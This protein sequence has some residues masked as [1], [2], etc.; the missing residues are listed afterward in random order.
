MNSLRPYMI[1]IGDLQ[2]QVHTRQNKVNRRNALHY[3]AP[4]GGGWGVVRVACLVPE[5]LVL[6]VIPIGCG[7]HGGVAALQ[8]GDSRMVRYLLVEE[9]EIVVGSYLD[10]VEKAVD[11]LIEAEKPAGMILFSTCMDDL[12]GADFDGIIRVASERHRIPVVRAKMNPIMSDTKKPPEVMIQHSIYQFLKYPAANET[13]EDVTGERHINVIGSFGQLDSESEIHE[14]LRH[15]GGYRLRHI[16]ECATLEAFESMGKSRLN[17]LVKPAGA[18]AV[19]AM[20]KRGKQ[21]FVEGF[22]AFRPAEINENYQQLSQ[23]LALPGPLDTTAAEAAAWHLME[24]AKPVLKG[25]T[26]AI[27]AT[28]NAR[29]FE[30]ARF[31]TELGIHVRY[32]LAKAVHDSEEKHVAWLKEHAPALQVIPDLDPSLS[33]QHTYVDQ[34][35]LCLGL[36]AAVYF[37]P[38]KL[39]E[40]PFDETL[41]GYRG[42]EKLITRIQEAEPYRYD[43]T[44]RIYRANLVV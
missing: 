1:P 21:P 20:A 13:P 34:V 14:A 41:Y 35:D 19:K 32:V 10:R 33:A 29:P 27:G 25:M 18:F 22:T 9:A 24:R 16:T 23:A 6:F 17:L 38:K 2:Q 37:E 28:L 5:I 4:S 31:L 44:Q 8:T 7:R 36:D 3:C 12:L 42:T 39:V 15:A 40:L 26:A 11:H 43:L 30:L